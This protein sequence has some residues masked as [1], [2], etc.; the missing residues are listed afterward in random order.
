MNRNGLIRSTLAVALVA[1]LTLTS[2]TAAMATPAGKSP[3]RGTGVYVK[4]NGSVIP[5]G[6]PN[7]PASIMTMGPFSAGS[8]VVSFSSRAD[9]GAVNGYSAD[10]QCFIVAD[11]GTVSPATPMFRLSP[12]LLLPLNYSVA[13]TTTKPGKIAVRCTASDGGNPI[14]GQVT[15]DSSQLMVQRVSTVHNG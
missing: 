9:T 15:V 13:I 10:I 2:V 5:L 14:P 6:P 1:G 4:Q 3:T 7:R 12:G 11:R 8:Y